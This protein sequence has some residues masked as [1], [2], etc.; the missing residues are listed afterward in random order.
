M[1]LYKEKKETEKWM[2]L[3][4]KSA[5]NYINSCKKVQKSAKDLVNY[6]I[7]KEFGSF[8]CI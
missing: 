6:S 4:E 8:E 1:N 7:I 3:L 2:K 5:K